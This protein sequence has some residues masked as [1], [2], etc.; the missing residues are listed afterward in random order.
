[1]NRAYAFG[2]ECKQIFQAGPG[3]QTPGLFNKNLLAILPGPYLLSPSRRLIANHSLP[4]TRVC[5][6]SLV[7]ILG[8]WW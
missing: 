1:M 4:L 7:L 5:F 3:K 8:D 6:R 2:I